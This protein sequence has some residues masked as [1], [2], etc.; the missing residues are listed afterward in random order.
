MFDLDCPFRSAAV[1]LE[2][3]SSVSKWVSIDKEHMIT[4]LY[5]TAVLVSIHNYWQN[6]QSISLND[7]YFSSASLALCTDGPRT[8]A[9][10]LELHGRGSWGT[11]APGTHPQLHG[12]SEGLCPI[13]HPRGE[14]GPTAVPHARVVATG[15]ALHA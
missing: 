12:T 4:P 3:Q 10:P 7:F 15:K 9:L 1:T 5:V 14:R 6:F 11:L 13:H 2:G 8:E